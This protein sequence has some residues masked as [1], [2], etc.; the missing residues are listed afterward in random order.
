[1]QVEVF[2]DAAAV[3]R[4]AAQFIAESAR[5]A[6]AER[7]QFVLAVSGGKTPWIMLRELAKEQLAWENVR[8]AQVD[9]RIAPAGHADRNLTHLGESLLA[10]VAL[11]P[12]QVLAMPVEDT[13]LPAAARHYEER[14]A[15][16]AGSPP[17][18]D[19]VHLGMGPDGHTA[20]LLPGD[21]ALD[22]SDAGVALTGEYQGR[23]RMTLTY[24]P[25]NRARQILWLVT[26]ADKAPM[27]PRLLDRDPSIPAGR[28]EQARA[29][30]LADS[31]AAAEMEKP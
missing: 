8:I 2:N 30:L 6:I 4:A 29:L 24:P 14:L 17:V 13:D 1:M 31:A 11:R 3:A 28:V 19:L 15:S 25:I 20:S 9:E 16:V 21:P 26:G 5:V 18:L 27:L 7:G 10:T 22:I 23:R 12:A